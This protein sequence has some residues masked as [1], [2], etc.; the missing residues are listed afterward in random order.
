MN[1]LFGNWASTLRK[2]S[3]LLVLSMLLPTF[4]MSNAVMAAEKVYAAYSSLEFAIPVSSLERYV[5]TGFIDLDLAGYEHYILPDKLQE[6]RQILNQPLK[7]NPLVAAHF[8]SSEQGEFLL[9]RFAELIKTKYGE[10]EVNFQALKTALISASAAPEGFTLLNLLRKYPNQSIHIDVASSLEIA[11]ELGKLMSATQQAI[12]S[13]QAQA[14]IEAANFPQLPQPPTPGNLS[15][16]QYQ[17]KFFDHKR[18]RLLLTDI[19]IP[20][21]KQAVPVIVVSHGLGLDSSNFRY[22]AHHLAAHGF[23]VVIP[24]H[25]VNHQQINSLLVE[26]RK[27]LTNSNSQF[28]D[29]SEFK[30]RP[31]D[32]KFILDELEKSNKSDARL[33]NRLNLQQVG[34]FGQSL[35]GYTALALAGAKI[36]FQQLRED[37]Q[38]EI[39]DKTWNISLLLQ[40]RA[41]ELP[42]KSS[43]KYNFRDERVKAAIAVNP[44]TS[45]IFGQQGL[46]HIQ[47]PVMIVGS[48]EDT[49]APSLPEQILPFSWV[50]QPHKYLVMLL[51][52]THF[53]TIG[54]S[55]EQSKQ[56][57]LPPEMVG[58]AVQARQSI[59]ALSLPFFQNYVHS[60]SEYLPY[61]KAAYAQSLST[62]SLKVNLV[63][64]LN[65]KQLAPLLDNP[66]K[67]LNPAKKKSLTL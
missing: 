41:L 55:S 63:Q 8:L 47:T 32:I 9:H 15:F 22:L 26:K 28:S 16:Q 21:V 46:S 31:L 54:N 35:G 7:I 19:Y 17:F 13:V 52:A 12:A 11:A 30:D 25:P 24:N 10:P 59:N 3:L 14:T 66:L 38:P 29:P 51:G 33:Q 18:Q 20:V 61:L 2:N 58:D 1:S 50:T 57:Q 60:Q 36:D 45:S 64:S 5:E 53:S 49:V 34:V 4:G 39:L 6:I 62:P 56:V 37:C 40:C 42:T 43:S 23:A 48:S 65:Q 44:I 27:S 67:G